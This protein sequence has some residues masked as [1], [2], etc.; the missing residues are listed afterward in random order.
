MVATSSLLFDGASRS[1]EPR[2]FATVRAGVRA[3]SREADDGGKKH[4]EKRSAAMSRRTP[5]PCSH[6]RKKRS[7]TR[8]VHPVETPLGHF[9]GGR[10]GGVGDVTE[11]PG[12]VE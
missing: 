1:G 6:E 12:H 5:K 7:E 3:A 11:I 2:G 4:R 10:C 8:L 9:R